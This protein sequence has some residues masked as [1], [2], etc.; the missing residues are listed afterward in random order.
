MMGKHIPITADALDFAATWVDAYE[1]SDDDDPNIVYLQPL[2]DWLTR[3]AQRRET[4]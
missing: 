2:I 4:K 1:P 3:E